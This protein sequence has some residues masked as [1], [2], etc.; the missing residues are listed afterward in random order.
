[1]TFQKGYKPVWSQ[2]SRK[3][4]SITMKKLGIKP[5]SMKGRKMPPWTE[6]HRKH[7]SEAQKKRD[8]S[9]SR[10]PEYRNERRERM[11]GNKHSVGKSHPQNQETRDKIS[12]KNLGRKRPEIAGNK[13]PNWKG[14]IT[15]EYRKIRTT[16]AYYN[17]RKSVFERDNYACIW[18][19]N[20]KSGTL[21][22]DHIKRFAVYPELRFE[23]SNGQTLCESCHKWKTRLDKKVYLGKVP[24]LNYA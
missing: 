17:W 13:N 20:N 8:W 18:C 16:T 21:N 6:E 3:K 10:T 5:P 24:E 7:L 15:S 19:S 22:A 14:G 1:M 2:E 12:K 23:L 4:L 9:F 11:L